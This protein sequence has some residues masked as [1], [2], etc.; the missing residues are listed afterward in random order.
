MRTAIVTATHPHP[1]QTFVNRHIQH[2]YGG[3]TCVVAV[4]GASGNPYGKDVLDL[5]AVPAGPLH[6]LG[7][8]AMRLRHMTSRVPWGRRARALKGF[9]AQNRVERVLV[10]HGTEAMAVAP[11]VAATGLPCW[12]YFRGADAGKVQHNARWREGYRRMMPRLTGIFAVSNFLLDVMAE[13]GVSHPNAHVIPSGVDVRS[14]APASKR[15]RS[16]L[17][18]GRM[19]P[20]KAPQV[21]LRAFA[22][23]ARDLPDA[24]LRFIGDGE[25]VEPCRALAASLGVADRIR[26]DGH[27]PHDDV[28][29]AMAE[30]AVFAQHSVTAPG[31]MVEGLPS[32]IQEAMACGCVV[33][34][35]RHAGIPEAVQDG[36]TGTLVDERDGA[37]FARGLRHALT[38]DMGDMSRA[39][40]ETAVR[41]FDSAILQRAVEEIMRAGR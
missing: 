10:E 22:D 25:E 23:A 17:A 15:P 26:F 5:T 1:G 16:V 24:T 38:S 29:A 39:A 35:T 8:I 12:S 34:S 32:A 40:R 36:R 11:V 6:P 18:V 30:S 3:D 14:F 41:R 31:G 9:L 13:V 2:L 27:R 33:V 7:M 19:I 37:G 4:R 20:M 21:T 28:R